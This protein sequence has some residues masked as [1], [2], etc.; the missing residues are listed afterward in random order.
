MRSVLAH[1]GILPQVRV[2]APPSTRLIEVGGDDYYVYSSGTAGYIEP[3]VELGDMVGR[4]SRRRKS[5]PPRRRG[6]S[7]RWWLRAR[8]AVLCKR[9]PGR[10]RR[11]DCLFHLATDFA[12]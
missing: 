10:T 8:R 9:I 2:A 12:G 7:P 6:R 1:M 3:L 4:A 11:G 5:T